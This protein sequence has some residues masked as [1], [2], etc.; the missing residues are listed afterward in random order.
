MVINAHGFRYNSLLKLA[1]RRTSGWRPIGRALI[2]ARVS[3]SLREMPS[4]YGPLCVISYLVSAVV[5]AA[6][7]PWLLISYLRRN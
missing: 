5:F 3:Y 2:L 4:A 1:L 7:G 6:I